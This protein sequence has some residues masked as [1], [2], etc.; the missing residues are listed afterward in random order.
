MLGHH[1]DNASTQAN[2]RAM[3]EWALHDVDSN[4][5]EL[6][7]LGC[8]VSIRVDAVNRSIANLA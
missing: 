1:L 8:V 6:H 3:I 4:A 7:I 2:E 5:H